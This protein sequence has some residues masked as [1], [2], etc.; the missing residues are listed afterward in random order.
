M[1]SICWAHEFVADLFDLFNGFHVLGNLVFRPSSLEA[2]LSLW[3]GCC[4]Y[5]EEVVLLC[6]MRLPIELCLHGLLP[7]LWQ[8]T[9]PQFHFFSELSTGGLLET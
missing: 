9:E 6:A 7:F 4:V 3:G 1:L 8:V 5:C 2:L